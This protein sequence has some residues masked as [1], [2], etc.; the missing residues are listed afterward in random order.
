LAVL[1]R[2]RDTLGGVAGTP[3]KRAKKDA[4]AAG[5]AVPEAAAAVAGARSAASR[6]RARSAVTDRAPHVRP[7]HV[8]TSTRNTSD[9]L[10]AGEL[11]QLS[12]QLQ[13]GAVLRLERVKPA[14]AGGWLC[15]YPLEHGELAEAYDFIRENYGGQTYKAT[16]LI[17]DQPM[18]T[19][20]ISVAGPP[21]DDGRIIERWM[22]EG[23]EPPQPRG[24][25][26]PAPAPAANAV[27]TML[28]LMKLLLEQQSAS[29]ASQL[30]AVR[31]SVD[32]AAAHSEALMQRVIDARAQEDERRHEADRRQSLA[33]QLEELVTASDAIGRAAEALGTR[34]TGAA[35]KTDDDGDDLLK[36]A[37]KEAVSHFVTNVMAS[38]IAPTN[39]APSPAPQ[40]QPQRQPPPGH[41]GAAKRRSPGIPEA[42]PRSRQPRD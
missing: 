37:A 10:A 41:N 12:A 13:P 39:A 24:A 1:A 29:N 8:G 32:R 3:R 16:V 23:G 15:D 11:A 42:G 35:A 26:A 2:P 34:A 25:A 20:K 5:D 19:A 17:G 33:G 4:A 38:Q 18:M 28:P 36:G 9:A 22:W 21:R 7:A 31:E 30:A 6:A 27:D 40:R 14:W